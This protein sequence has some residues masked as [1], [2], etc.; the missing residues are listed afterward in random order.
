MENGKALLIK[1]TDSIF[2]ISSTQK[3]PSNRLDPLPN[4]P[5]KPLMNSTSGYSQ[6]GTLPLA[7]LRLPKLP[8]KPPDSHQ[9]QSKP[10]RKRRRV[11]RKSASKDR[12]NSLKRSES[13]TP[14]ETSLKRPETP[15][16]LASEKLDYIKPVYCD[17]NTPDPRSRPTTSKAARHDSAVN[18][19]MQTESNV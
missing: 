2:S 19:S 10:K 12:R 13:S 8:A 11:D 7:S 3:K 18:R 17:T 1:D 4:R 6:N 5:D 9:M 15:D 14:T 16:M